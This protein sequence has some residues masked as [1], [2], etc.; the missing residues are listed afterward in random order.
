MGPGVSYQGLGGEEERG[1]EG[2]GGGGK[3][4]VQLGH[5]PTPCMLDQRRPVRRNILRSNKLVQAL[6]V[7]KMTLYNVR[8]A[9]AKWN[10][11]AEDLQMRETD[12]M[13]L[14]EVWE[15][16][17]NRKHQKAIEEMLELKGLKYVST[18]RPG[19]RRGGGTALISA[20]VNFRLTKLNINI[21][22]PLE[23]CFSLLRPRNPTGNLTKF[24]CI[25][26]YSPPKSRS[27]KKLIE[28]LTSTVFQLRSEHPNSGL[29]MGADINDLKLPSLL[30]Y[31][32]SL[33]QIVRKCTNKNRDKVLDCFITDLHSLLQ[34][35]TILPPIQVDSDKVG[36]DSDHMGVECIPRNHLVT[37]GSH[38]R[39]KV[40]VQPFPESGLSEMGVT[41][42]EEGWEV[43]TEGMSSSEMVKSFEDHSKLLVD[44]QFPKKVVLVGDKDLPYF[45]EDLRKLKR[46]RQRAYRV[47]GRRSGKY[48]NLKEK[49]DSKLKREA[50]KYVAKIEREVASGVK[51]SGY[52]AIRKL[53]NRPGESGRRKEVVV[54]SYLEQKLSPGEAANRLACY[55]AAVSQ[56]VEPL[57]ETKF[58]PA[59]R[60]ELEEGRRSKTKPIITQHQ[61]YCKMLRATKPHSSVLGDVPIPVLKKYPYLYSAPVTR[62]FNKI[63]QASDWPQTWKEEQIIVLPKSPNLLVQ[64]ED[65]LRNIAKTPWFS[66]LLEN[67][68]HDYILPFVEPYLDPGQCGGLKG[69]SATHYLIKLTDFLH[70]T[71]DKRTPH[72]AVLA[73]EDLSRAYNR[74]S[75]L[76]VVEDLFSMHLPGWL[77]AITCSYLSGRTMVLHYQRSKSS[78]QHLP[79]GFSAGTL[80]GGLFFVIKFNGVCLRPPIPRPMSGRRKQEIGN[81][82][83][84]MS[85]NSGFQVKYID[86]CTQAASINLR[87]SL[88][89]DTQE[90]PRPLNFHERTQ[91]VLNPEEDILQQE[92]RRFNKEALE[93]RL[94]V[95]QKN[96]I[97]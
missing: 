10:N 23:A 85:G 25:S 27:N 9:W 74:G 6:S 42:M 2:A 57:D 13:F 55:F 44:Q 16:S 71:L 76:L 39:E 15:K 53:G 35:P 60:L 65:D 3:I 84:E 83:Q 93:N 14:T 21:P 91:M 17:E 34:E 19:A 87:V 29:I 40:E 26:F 4:P 54:P 51:G 72:C 8:S 22:H 58:H 43:M 80:F 86:D 49:F 69:S 20:E 30:S 36:K 94:A 59:L 63:I 45:N 47:H 82:K 32:P 88:I 95:N 12:V 89:P 62:I 41:L 28:F 66:K 78:P 75:H 1:V 31:D 7:P 67:L 52:K 18:P 48:V 38:L 33:K 73:T 5:R 96:L 61:V 56:T 64:S 97:L 24:I 68:L 79:G 46:Q 77:L 70:R 11:I 92:M 50:L 90:R 37:K 81:R